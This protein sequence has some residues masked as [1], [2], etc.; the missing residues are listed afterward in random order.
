MN[1]IKTDFYFRK[2][3]KG[4]TGAGKI[5]CRLSFGGQ[6]LELSLGIKLD[7]DEWDKKKQRPSGPSQAAMD[8]QA[9]IET[10]LYKVRQYRIYLAE[11]DK[12]VDLLELKDR[13]NPSA[14]KSLGVLEYYKAHN[15]RVEELIGM[16]YAKATHT[17][18]ET[19]RK[20]L[21][22]FIR[23]IRKRKDFPLHRIDRE[24][25]DDFEH[26]LKAHCQIGHNTTARY[27][28]HFKKIT[29]QAN[30]EDKLRTDP[31]QG[32]KIRNKKVY[33]EVLNEK[34]L[35]TLMKREFAIER[36]ERVRDIFLFSCFT[37]LSYAEIKSISPSN[38]EEVQDGL[39]VIFITRKKTK[40]LSTIPLMDSA[41]KILRKYENHPDCKRTGK[42]LP[43]PSNQKMNAYLKEI[44][45]LCG[46]QK[47]ITCHMARRTFATTVAALNGI[48]IEH[49]ATMMGHAD[50]RMTMQYAQLDFRS[51]LTTLRKV[52]LK[53]AI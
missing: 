49:I 36:L 51:I 8:V 45:D 44:G 21:G 46:I 7:K 11:M 31:F 24:F 14:Q 30:R 27:L 33:Q 3:R 16:E 22:E 4:P 29:L 35:Q 40:E 48:P 25:I 53:Y 12:P 6:Q 13:L 34:E 18:Y 9:E 50:V 1:R 26:Y 43:T 10:L 32:K 20:H 28:K 17:R 19:V 2:V 23:T 41:A 52:D 5:Y 42:S 47:D 39:D 38:I 37:G 15:Q